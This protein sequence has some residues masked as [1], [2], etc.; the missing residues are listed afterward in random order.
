MQEVSR[1]GEVKRSN[2][3]TLSNGASGAKGQDSKR[4]IRIDMPK[5]CRIG[6]C[7]SSETKA[8]KTHCAWMMTLTDYPVL[9]CLS[10]DF[11]TLVAITNPRLVLLDY[12]MSGTQPWASGFRQS[13]M[14][15]LQFWRGG[16]ICPQMELA[17]CILILTFKYVLKLDSLAISFLYFN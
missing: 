10:L 9:N 3:A 14:R 13:S 8:D 15:P 1:W 11:K 2:T 12:Y 4:F 5:A 16:P 17:T 6:S 7:W